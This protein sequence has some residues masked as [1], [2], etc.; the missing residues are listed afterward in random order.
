MAE[1]NG[2]TPATRA[3]ERAV[4][5]EA[6]GTALAAFIREHEYCGELDAGLDGDRFWMTC[7][8]SATINRDAN[9]D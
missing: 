3:R 8:C 9:H 6:L 4:M 1:D 5:T 2:S 7:T